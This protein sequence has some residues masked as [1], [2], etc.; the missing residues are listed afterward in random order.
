MAAIR[1]SGPVAERLRAYVRARVHKEGP[2]YERRA[3]L[4][5]AERIGKAPSW[6]S[7]YV[8]T[9]PNAN[10]DIDTALAICAFFN[11]D[12]AQFIDDGPRLSRRGSTVADVTNGGPTD[13]PA[14]ASRAHL[15]KIAALE[16]RIKRYEIA[17][18]QVR[19]GARRIAKLATVPKQGRT[20]ARR[21]A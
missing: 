10:A 3:G 20:P 19:D 11:V 6:V 15:R 16:T 1:G 12:F 4:D 7:E 14:S 17:L 8:A 2:H 18:E 13:V 9:P 21:R 5:L